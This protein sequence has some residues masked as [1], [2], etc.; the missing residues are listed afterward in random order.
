MPILCNYYLTYRCNAYCDFCHFGDHDAF[1][2]SRHAQTDDVLA[3]LHDLRE[4]GVRF[5]DL[6]GANRSCIRTSM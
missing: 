1:R 2:G 3:N 4:L 5:I 6:T